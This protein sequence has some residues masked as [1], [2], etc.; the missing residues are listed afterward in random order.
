MS[1]SRHTLINFAGAAAPIALTVATIPLYLRTIGSDR[2]GALVAIW[3]I[4]GYFSLFDLGLG[5][6]ITQ[7]LSPATRPQPERLNIIRLGLVATLIMGCI[8]ATLSAPVLRWYFNH[9]IDGTDSLR[10][11]LL[12]G[13]PWMTLCI[14]I[15][16]MS[17]LCIGILES[18]RR[19]DVIVTASLIGS[20]LSQI[21]PLAV[22]LTM[23]KTLDALVP[24]VAMGRAL[25]LTIMLAKIANAEKKL[26]APPSPAKDAIQFRNLFRFGGWV[27][28]S[29]I[30]TPILV[31][32]DK[33]MLPSAASLQAT[34]RY[35]IS[36]SMASMI[37]LIPN[38]LSTALFPHLTAC[39]DPQSSRAMTARALGSLSIIVTPLV[40]IGMGFSPLVLH[41]WLGSDFAESIR[42]CT[43]LL[44]LA[45]WP[46][47]LAYVPY[48]RLHANGQPR[49]V[50]LIHVTQVL[51][52]LAALAAVLPDYG[53]SGAAACWAGRSFVDALML[54]AAAKAL[55]LPTK[56]LMWDAL[57]VSSF[58]LLTA[59]NPD[60]LVAATTSA[61]TAIAYLATKWRTI[62][63]YMRN[64]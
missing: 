43:Q 9:G 42:A 36:F 29:N 19:F 5:K 14:P 6:S 55:V 59:G 26:E 34:G 57:W 64:D 49:T 53:L 12:E 21:A 46:H 54:F 8:G 28:L 11:E 38:S 24:F 31:N 2:Y 17:S 7:A 52:Y 1:L 35:N 13:L 40:I 4:I 30:T 10:S 16:A 58:F 25:T 20:A 56:L 47:A 22:A 44:M 45:M 39:V 48:V 3:L 32:A 27:T 62:R 33:L 15:S 50:A 23:T 41:I 60:M 61:M 63:T 51:P 37:A 18:R